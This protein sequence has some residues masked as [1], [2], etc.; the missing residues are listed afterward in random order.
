MDYRDDTL[1]RHAALAHWAEIAIDAVK[2]VEGYEF[3]TPTAIYYVMTED[4]ANDYAEDEAEHDL[5]GLQSRCL[6]F[7]HGQVADYWEGVRL[8]GRGTQI[9]IDTH[10]H[11]FGEWFIY[12]VANR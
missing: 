6:P 5:Q 11:E 9:A 2:H 1:D 4:E 10:E 12:K 8:A 7:S 3:T